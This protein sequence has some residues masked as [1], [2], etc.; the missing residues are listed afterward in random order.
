MQIPIQS[1]WVGPE[2]LHFYQALGDK[3]DMVL[4]IT[5]RLVRIYT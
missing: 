1:I 5:F 2:I 3:D 4:P